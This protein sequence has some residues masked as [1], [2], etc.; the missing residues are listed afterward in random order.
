MDYEP[1][2]FE[3]KTEDKKMAEVKKWLKSSPNT[4]REFFEN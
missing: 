3:E 4:E 1:E 2:Q